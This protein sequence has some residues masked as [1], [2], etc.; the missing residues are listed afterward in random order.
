MEKFLVAWIREKEKCRERL[1]SAF[2]R[3]NAKNLFESFETKRPR[4]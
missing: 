1:A 3:E 4:M 2:I